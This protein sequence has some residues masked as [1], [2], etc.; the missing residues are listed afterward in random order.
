M[1]AT[2]DLP[3]GLYRRVKAKSALEGRAIRDV[4]AE[5]FESYLRDAA[6]R[7]QPEAHAS[8]TSELPGRSLPP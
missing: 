2:I 7:G 4:T 5:L 6:L 1:K 8:S 3:D